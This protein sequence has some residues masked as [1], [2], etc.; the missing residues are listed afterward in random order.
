M[1]FTLQ[2]VTMSSPEGCG[3]LPDSCYCKLLPEQQ[4]R[5]QVF[6][7]LLELWIRRD[8]VKVNDSIFIIISLVC[9]ER[10]AYV[11]VKQ[12]SLEILLHQ[13]ACCAN[14]STNQS[15]RHSPSLDLSSVCSPLPPVL[16]LRR[17]SAFGQRCGS[18]RS[19]CETFKILYVLVSNFSAAFNHC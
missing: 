18:T 14:R 3:Y 2:R 7:S 8:I 9:F 1:T 10:S 13:C 6:R 19:D 17:Q 12:I 11:G 4:F 5:G 16:P 15:T